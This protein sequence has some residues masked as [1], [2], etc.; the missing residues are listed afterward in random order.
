MEMER[1]KVFID[2]LEKYILERRKT[3]KVARVER[4]IFALLKK[5]GYKGY[6]LE[7]AKETGI[8]PTDVSATLR[9]LEK[10]NWL[11]IK[12]LGKGKRS[13]VTLNMEKLLREGLP[14]R[15][16]YE[17]KVLK[18]LNENH[19]SSSTREIYSKVWGRSAG[20]I[21]H[22]WEKNPFFIHH[23]LYRV[24]RE[25]QKKGLLLG[26]KNIITL[27]KKGE[28]AFDAY[29]KKNITISN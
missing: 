17:W 15:N 19:K 10:N 23:H 6:E 8:H 20:L 16:D 9:E 24:L 7:I 21:T 4:I 14:D 5:P 12:S 22:S 18:F 25:M 27:T 28:I 3:K 1:I 11:F 13:E 2:T 26:E 29:R